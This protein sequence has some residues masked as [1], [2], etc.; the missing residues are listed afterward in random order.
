MN[1]DSKNRSFRIVNQTKVGEDCNS[2]C[3][4]I[5]QEKFVLTCRNE[6]SPRI[7]QP[8]ET[9]EREISECQGGAETRQGLGFKRVL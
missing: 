4:T 7:R 6:S 9:R 8:R 1:L 5:E 2:S 3:I